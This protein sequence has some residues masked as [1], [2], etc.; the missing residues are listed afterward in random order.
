M[1]LFFLAEFQKGHSTVLLVNI[2]NARPDHTYIARLY[3]EKC[4]KEFQKK[5]SCWISVPSNIN[6][7]RLNVAHL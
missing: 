4:C 1:Q 5:V 3:N 6:Q 2:E 7:N